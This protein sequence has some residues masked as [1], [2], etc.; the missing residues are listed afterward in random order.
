MQAI[1]MMLPLPWHI[2][3]AAFT[4]VMEK[5][6]QLSA[7]MPYSITRFDCLDYGLA[8]LNAVR[9]NRPAGITAHAHSRQCIYAD[10][11][12]GKVV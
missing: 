9:G 3:A 10:Q 8:V 11:Y 4:T 5:M 2:N 7:S 1:N 12:R 6:Q